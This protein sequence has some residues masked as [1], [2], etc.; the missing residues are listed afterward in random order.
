MSGMATIHYHLP[1]GEVRSV[2]LGSGQSVM[3]GAMR[4]DLPGIE[5]I[6][7]G[8]CSCGTCQVY[9]SEDWIDRLDQPGP[10]EEAILDFAPHARP[11]SRLACQIK[12]NERLD[13]LVVELLQS[14]D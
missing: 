2:A 5:A 13:G 8:C 11:N 3:E 7:G 6:C 14:Q 1:G 12:I 10:D 4:E 9:V